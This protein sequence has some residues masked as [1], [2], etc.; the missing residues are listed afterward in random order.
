MRALRFHGPGS[1]AVERVTVPEPRPGEVL[2]RVHACGIC[3]SDRQFVTGSLKAPATPV[4]LG[5]EM[6]GT[7]VTSRDSEWPAGSEVVAAPAVH[8]GSCPR[9]LADRPMLCERLSMVGIDIDGGMAEYAVVPGRALTIKPDTVGWSEA[10]T[11]AD[12]GLTACHA[13]ACRAKVTAGTSVLVIGLG[14]VGQYALAIARH[15]GAAPIIAM[16]PSPLARTASSSL[17]ADELLDT[18][19]V[20]SRQIKM[21]TGGGVDTAIDCVGSAATTHLAVMSLRAGGTAVVVGIGAEPV[22]TIPTVLWARHEYTLTGSFGGHLMDLRQV[23]Q[24]LSDGTLPSIATTELGLD[25]APAALLDTAASG[26]RTI[27]RP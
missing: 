25:D 19:S 16:D 11:A 7:V 24:W 20:D 8:C 13:V 6:A 2:L 14:G 9:C 4:T 10:A 17:G 27:I 1:V 18:R 5:H 21:L 15:L 12:A 22:E 26:R 23:L 3:G